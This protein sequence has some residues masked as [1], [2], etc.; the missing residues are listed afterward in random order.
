[1]LMWLAAA[2]L[3]TPTGFVQ[4]IY[5]HHRHAAFDPLAQ[6]RRYFSPELT[7]AIREDE[8]LAHGEVGYLDGDPLCDCQDT[9][10]MRSSITS[11]AGS[12]NA[13]TAH[14]LVRFDGTSDRRDILLKLARTPSGWRIA[15]VGTADEPSLL[16]ALLGANRK[17]RAR[18]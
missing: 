10:G 17:A 14:L 18:H 13:A 7:A 6:P 15:D 2:A 3:E 8:R 16:H 9:G 12:R 1:M 4:R 11:V 5:G